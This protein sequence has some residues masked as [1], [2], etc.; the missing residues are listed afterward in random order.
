MPSKKENL[1]RAQLLAD[2]DK[3]V[4]ENQE[5]GLVVVSSG[6]SD[7]IPGSDNDYNT[8]FER[9]DRI[10]YERK[11]ELKERLRQ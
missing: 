4:E 11:R 3:K 6:M 7:C 2:F 5:N 9:A 1:D 8:V 10:M